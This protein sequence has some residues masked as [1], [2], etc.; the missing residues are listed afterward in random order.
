MHRKDTQMYRL[1]YVSA[2]TVPFSKADLVDLLTKAREKNQKAG[3]SG[4]LLYQD[5]D[6]LQLIEGERSAVK[7]L[8]EVIKADPRH[9]G[10]IVVDEEE[11]EDRV[12][13]DWSMGFRDLSDPAVQAI[14]G[15]S[16]FMNTPLVAESFANHPSTAL[17]FLSMFKPAY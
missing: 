5:G 3:I 17:Q 15:F 10:T 8:F 14:P 4:M 6:F 11:A 7:E 2:A 1:V 13:A 9:S 12:F 16:Q